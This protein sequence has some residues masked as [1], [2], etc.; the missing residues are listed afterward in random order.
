M[1][2]GSLVGLG[3]P[4]LDISAEV[5][6]EFLVKYGLEANNATLAEPKHIPAYDRVDINAFNT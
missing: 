4:L 1:T 6:A 2:S 3:N 5:T